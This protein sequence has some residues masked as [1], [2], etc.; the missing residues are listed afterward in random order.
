MW[1]SDVSEVYKSAYGVRSSISQEAKMAQPSSQFQDFIERE[2]PPVSQVLQLVLY[3]SH[4]SLIIAE[5]LLECWYEFCETS[6]CFSG[7]GR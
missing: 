1:R 7:I 3:P 4:N 5:Y 6:L 2:M